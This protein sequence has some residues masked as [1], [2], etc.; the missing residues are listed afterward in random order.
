MFPIHCGLFDNIDMNEFSYERK[1]VPKFYDKI[2]L[3]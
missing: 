2:D 3:E 1:V